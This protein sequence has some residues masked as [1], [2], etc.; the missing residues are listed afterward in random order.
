MGIVNY[1]VEYHH[2]VKK[3]V[4]RIPTNIKDAIKKAIEKRLIVDPASYSRPLSRDL[5]GLRKLKIG[6]YRVILEINGDVI[7]ILKIGHRSEVYNP[8]IRRN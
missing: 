6:H 7:M 5:T 4:K 2:D 1:K 3:D 8:P